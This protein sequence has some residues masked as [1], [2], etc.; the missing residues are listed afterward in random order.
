MSRESILWLIRAWQSTLALCFESGAASKSSTGSLTNT[1]PCQH[2]RWI[3]FVF[4]SWKPK[5]A[6]LSHSRQFRP[7]S[8]F[9]SFSS[10]SFSHGWVTVP[11]QR[12]KKGQADGAVQS[13]QELEANQ[14][15]RG[16]R[17]RETGQEGRWAQRC[18]VLAQTLN[19]E[20]LKFQ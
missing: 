4:T 7:P 20:F 5:L 17:R 2:Y 13:K 1:R 18:G 16:D 6:I 15:T 19:S 10:P 8:D 3:I 11:I 9:T 12:S 14:R